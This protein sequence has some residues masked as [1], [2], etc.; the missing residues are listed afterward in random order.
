MVKN[1]TFLWISD[2]TDR[3]L[4]TDE[5][6]GLAVSLTESLPGACGP[7]N[8]AASPASLTLAAIRRLLLLV[9]GVASE[10]PLSWQVVAASRKLLDSFTSR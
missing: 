5:Q 9:V 6:R 4:N 1:K 7:M 3:S 8:A 2:T 10:P